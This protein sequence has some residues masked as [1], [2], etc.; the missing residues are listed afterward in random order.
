MFYCVTAKYFLIFFQDE[1]SYV[2][3]FSSY[4]EMLKVIFYKTQ[5]YAL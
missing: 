5:P 1:A 3:M 2:E 4:I